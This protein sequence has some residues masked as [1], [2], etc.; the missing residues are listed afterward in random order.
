[1]EYITSFINIIK[2]KKMC[3]LY[4]RFII[5]HKIYIFTQMLK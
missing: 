4:F 1:M 3:Q 5:S 2:H